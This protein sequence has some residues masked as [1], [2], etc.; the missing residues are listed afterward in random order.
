MPKVTVLVAARDAATTIEEAIQSVTE[1]EFRDWECVVVDDGSS[2]D[3]A[4]RVAAFAADD[5]RIRL[6]SQ[7]AMGVVP[8]RNTGLSACRSPF[9]AIL[10]ADDRMAPQRLSD[11]VAMLERRQDLAGVGTH[12]AYFP[13]DR[14]GE[15][16]RAYEAWLNGQDTAEGLRKDRFI[17]M[18]LGHPTLMLRTEAI[19]ALP[20]RDMGWPEDWDLL[21]RL[22]AEGR[23]LGVVAEVHHHW[24]LSAASLSRISPAYAEDAF[25]RCRAHFLARDFLADQRSYGLIG[26]GPTGKALRKA[27]L[28]LSRD[29]VAIYE[30]HPGRIGQVIDGAEVWHHEQL[31]ERV[32]HK[33]LVSVAGA[34]ARAFLRQ[35]LANWGY[36]DGTDFVCT[37]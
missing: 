30:L 13:R 17:E 14:C 1:Q 31:Q 27:L 4:A 36:R 26:F 32:P 7:S 25:T 18:P 37:A 28:P 19:R 5:R 24:R 34:E 2:D 33:L 35:R 15:G 20:Y 10:D 6:L 21:L 8:A 23:A 16:R 11:Q 9:I 12:V 22:F 29:C 3:T